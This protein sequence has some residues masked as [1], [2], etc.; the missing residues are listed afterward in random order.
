MKRAVVLGTL[1][2]CAAVFSVVGGT[3]EVAA[4]SRKDIKSVLHKPLIMGASVSAGF[5][6]KGP[7]TRAAERFTTKSNIKNIARDQMPAHRYKNIGPNL[8]KN[9][10]AVIAVDFL[11]WDT[12]GFGTNGSIEALDKLI[13][14]TRALDI[15]LVIGDVPQVIPFQMSRD[16]INRELYA[17]CHAQHRC[18]ILP[19]VELHR[20]ANQD[21]IVINGKKY[22]FKELTTD[23]LHL[24]AVASQYVANMIVRILSRQ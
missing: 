4:Q 23:G 15:P 7:G 13:S 6:T 11:F 24:N 3:S 16:N 20:R 2:A 21:G 22:S 19:L 14:T 12:V 5:S 8:L 18:Y 1:L 10:T 17:R 9:H